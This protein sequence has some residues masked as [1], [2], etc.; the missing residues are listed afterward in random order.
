MSAYEPF[1]EVVE[2][3]IAVRRFE[4]AFE[5]CERLPHENRQLLLKEVANRLAQQM[6]EAPSE[7]QTEVKVIGIEIKPS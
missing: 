3:R 4:S 2:Y 6:P 1:D 5:A 7:E